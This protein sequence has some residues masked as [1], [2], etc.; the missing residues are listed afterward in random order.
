MKYEESKLL[1]RLA[2]WPAGITKVLQ[3]E[4][5]QHEVNSLQEQRERTYLKIT[6]VRNI[7]LLQEVRVTDLLHRKQNKG[8]KEWNDERQ[9]KQAASNMHRQWG[10]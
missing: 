8:H 7:Q 10:Y 2:L 4:I 5:T 1:Q 9:I 6:D 3:R